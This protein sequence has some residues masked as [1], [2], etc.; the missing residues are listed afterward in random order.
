MDTPSPPD[1]A[2]PPEPPA[3][4]P[5]PIVLPAS[6]LPPLAIPNDEP[7][8]AV[9]I[10]QPAQPPR[11]RMPLSAIVGLA[12]VLAVVMGLWV[13]GGEAR[14]FLL[15][16]AILPPMAALPLLAYLGEREP[17][18]R[19]VAIVFWLLL[20]GGAAG[21]ILLT[22]ATAALGPQ[23][24]DAV[25]LGRPL[26]VA[27]KSA[28]PGSAAK[29][30]W[31]AGGVSVGFALGLLCF[32]PS[33]RAAAARR[34]PLDP[35]SFV[36]ALALATVVALT[37]MSF[38]PLLVL[39]AP[40]ALSEATSKQSA[41]QLQQLPPDMMLRMTCYLYFWVIVG[42]VFFVGF[43]LVR[44][45][46]AAL[47]RL[48]LVVPSLGQVAFGLAAAVILLVVTAGVEWL[49]AQVWTYFQW[50]RTDEK[51]FNEL[52]KY[53][54]SPIGAVVVGIT[55]GLSEEMAVRGILQP[56]LGILLSNLFFTALHALQYN[57]DA[58]LSVFLIGL[59]LGLI[60]RRFNTT[61]SAITHGTYD[62]LSVL[63]TYYMPPG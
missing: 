22:T 43:P 28:P 46:P 13:L 45:L 58:L 15:C 25:Q 59:V 63:L 9:P 37:T 27:L 10:L 7:L 61:T 33:V 38:V 50:P 1:D 20:T 39:K 42:F 36:H 54:I 26:K 18:S 2:P 57:W 52:L 3:D 11:R 29:I 40:P 12:A 6:D 16:A 14:L 5:P 8:L 60:R 35:R 21:G 53:A 41:E 4:E 17:G 51:A 48:G 19:V 56:R 62:F 47:V 32:A 44:S 55:A 30:A 49:I 24:M 23:V 31:S 34:L